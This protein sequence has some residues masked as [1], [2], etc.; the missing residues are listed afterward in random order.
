M[1]YPS[2]G[3]TKAERDKAFRQR[4]AEKISAKKKEKYAANREAISAKRRAEYAADIEA[5]RALQRV[6]ALID[7]ETRR[8]KRRAW[9]QRNAEKMRAY[10]AAQK[11]KHA[12]ST[13]AINQRRRALK[14]AAPGTLTADDI[15]AVSAAQGHRCAWCSLK[16]KLTV[17][18][19]TPLFRGGHHTKSN[20]QMLCRSCNSK[21]G[22]ADPI[23][24]AQREGLLL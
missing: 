2:S 3:L 16:R 14:A 23:A 22:H 24:F 6:R 20:I 13:R 15:A 5:R 7:P 12:E 10:S 19:I 18:H 9:Y 1:P 21:K 11:R 4:H 17:D 8:A